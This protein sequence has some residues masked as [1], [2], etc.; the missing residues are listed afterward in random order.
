M[1]RTKQQVVQE[2]LYEAYGGLWTNFTAISENFVLRKVNNYIAESAVK[3]AFGSYNLDGVVE[4]DDIFR[5][6]YTGISLTTDANTG[7]KYFSLPAQPV[8]LPSERSYI[9]YPPAMRGGR[10]SSI[11]KPISASTVTKVRSLPNIK[12]VFFYI[13]N[14]NCYFV[15]SYQIMATYNSVNLSIVTG[16]ANNLTDFLNMPDD[17]INGIKMAVVPQIRVMMGAQDSTPIPPQDSPQPRE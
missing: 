13:E 7:L 5:L 3:S 14:G 6:T 8:G 1:L 17:M 4:A 9:I 10:Q 12:K 11:F 2:I 16:G 15:D